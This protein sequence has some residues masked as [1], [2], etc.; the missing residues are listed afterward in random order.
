MVVDRQKALEK[1][2]G[3]TTSLLE[4]KLTHEKRQDDWVS[5]DDLEEMEVVYSIRMDRLRDLK[6]R[7]YIKGLKRFFYFNQ[8][9]EEKYPHFRPCD[10][11][12]DY[13]NPDEENNDAYL[14][15]D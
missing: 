14:F 8:Y 11:Q 5:G 15:F 12:I 9:D 10:Q 2:S 4:Y 6:R 7:P 3:I 1:W 13:E